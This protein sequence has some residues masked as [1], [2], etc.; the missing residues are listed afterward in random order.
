[1]DVSHASEAWLGLARGTVDGKTQEVRVGVDQ[2]V[3]TEG[4]RPDGALV[5]SLEVWTT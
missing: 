3:L 1:M 2:P 5:I 4:H